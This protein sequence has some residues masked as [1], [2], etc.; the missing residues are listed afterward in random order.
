MFAGDFFWH[1]DSSRPFVFTSMC[2][3]KSE[4][5]RRVF[6]LRNLLEFSCMSHLIPSSFSLLCLVAVARTGTVR[7]EQKERFALAG[8]PSNLIAHSV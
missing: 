1:V 6:G 5:L 8:R 3:L 7:V 2:L 4:Q